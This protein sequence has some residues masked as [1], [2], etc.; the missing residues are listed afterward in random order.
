MS[1]IEKSVMFFASDN[2]S[3][4]SEKVLQAITNANSGHAMPYGADDWSKAAEEKISEV[5]ERDCAVFLVPTGTA[6]NALSLAAF[7]PPYGAVFCHADAHVMDDECGAP[8]FFTHGAKLVGIEGARGKIPAAGL[9][10]TLAAYPRGLVKQVQPATLTLSQ[11]T[12][13]GTLY[14]VQEVATLADIAHRRGVAVHMDGARFAN[15]LVSLG[16][17]PADLT[18]KAGVDVLSLG[19]TKNG[20]I[21]CEAVVFFD[22]DRAADFLYLRKRG[23]HTVSKGRFIGAQMLA[24]LDAGHWLDL[25]RHANAMAARLADGLAAIPGVRLPWR[26]QV[27]EVF[28]VLP[29]SV[30]RAL[31]AAQA[32]YYDWGGRGLEENEKLKPGEVFVRMVTSFA[33][34]PQDVDD[35]LAIARGAGPG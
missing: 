4:A 25:A 8:E 31:R 5:F 32:R 33:T 9:A 18:W 6:A 24:W 30:D 23:G 19:G 35:C 1:R 34:A 27:N 26:P 21:M 3:G 20:A 22:R 15:A 13:S 2:A 17:A 28:A 12:E 7:T 11:A 10:A 29:E 14:S 16:C